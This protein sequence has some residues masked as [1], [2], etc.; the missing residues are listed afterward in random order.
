MSTAIR[1]LIVDDEPLARQRLRDLLSTRP[2][3]EILAEAENGVQAVQKVESL[4]PELVFLDVQMPDIDGFGVLRLVQLEKMPLVIFVTAYEQYAVDAFEVN[5]IDYLLKPISRLRLEQALTRVRERLT[6]HGTIN[7]QLNTL[8]KNVNWQPTTYLQ[9]LPVRSRNSILVL[10]L[11]Q[12]TS[13]RLNG[14]LVYATTAEGEF[15]TKYTTFTEL[16]NL[17]DPQCFLRIHR[18]VIVNIDHVREVTAYDKHSARLTLTGG[19]QVTVSRRHLK[20]LWKTIN[21]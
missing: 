4:L 21:W 5:A 10:P 11:D 1:T 6:S 8:L 9:R 13:L 20:E 18:Q 7:K 16:E 14:G 19:L 3:I 17:L 12:I 2:D 15:W